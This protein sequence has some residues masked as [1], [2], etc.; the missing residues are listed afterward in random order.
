MLQL[1]ECR[2]AALAVPGGPHSEGMVE[3]Q[4]PPSGKKDRCA[5]DQYER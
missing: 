5:T 3:Q 1:E 4:V 2:D